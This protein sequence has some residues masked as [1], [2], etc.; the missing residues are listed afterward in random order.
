MDAPEPQE[1]RH[2]FENGPIFQQ[3]RTHGPRVWRGQNWMGFI[4]QDSTGIPKAIGNLL[5][6]VSERKSMYKVYNI[7]RHP[8]MAQSGRGQ[9]SC[10]EGVFVVARIP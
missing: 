8:Q 1:G 2:G 5:R 3:I 10:L 9:S 7:P 4:R 6:F